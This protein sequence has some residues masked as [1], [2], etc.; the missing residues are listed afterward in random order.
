MGRWNK[1]TRLQLC[2]RRTMQYAKTDFNFRI[3]KCTAT[4]F[5]KKRKQ[6]VNFFPS[7]LGEIIIHG[8]GGDGG[9][10]RNFLRV[11]FKNHLKWLKRG[12]KRQKIS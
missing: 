3:P 4:V 2:M 11:L 7:S 1:K 10:G 5:N 8:H 9:D 12:S 6:I